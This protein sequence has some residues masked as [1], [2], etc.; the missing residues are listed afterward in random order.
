MR[1]CSSIDG[2]GQ[3]RR[4]ALLAGATREASEYYKDPRNAAKEQRK[5]NIPQNPFRNRVDILD[6]TS[7][8]L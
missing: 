4:N 1:N 3:A 8:E 6:Q 5:L 7:R 2:V